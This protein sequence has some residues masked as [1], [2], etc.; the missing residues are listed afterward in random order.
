M[1]DSTQLDVVL[2]LKDQMSGKLAGIKGE[3]SSFGTNL[4]NVG[5]MVAAGLATASVAVGAFGVSS[6]KAFADAEASQNRFETA[7]RNIAHAGDDQIRM[8]RDQQNALSQTTR[9]EDD[10]IAS[11][12]GFLAT[13]QLSGEQI[14]FLTPRLL[15]MSEGLRDSTGATMG[16]EQASNML[17][18]AV[19]LGTV[20]M[21][22]KAG[23]TIP[24]TTKA[25]QDL[26]KKNFEL[27][28]IQERVKMIGDFVDGNFKGQAES[29]G[30]TLAGAIDILKNNFQ[31]LQEGIGGTLSYALV[32][33]IKTVSEFVNKPETLEWFKGMIDKMQAMGSALV[34]YLTPAFNA[35][36]DFFSDLENR[37]AAITA[38]LA[39]LTIAFVAWGVS[40]VTSMA[41]ITLA[42]VALGIVIFFLAKLWNENFGGI[43]EKTQS[44]FSGIVA[45]YQQYL[46][47]FFTEIRKKTDEVVKWWIDNW[48]TISWIFSGVWDVIRGVFTVAWALFSGAFKIAIDL[49]TGN[50]KKAWED[51]KS[52]F[53][54]IF[55]G[56]TL[57]FTGIAKTLM[58][59]LT[60]LINGFINKIN[61]VLSKINKI[62]GKD[63]K[64]ANVELGDIPAM[65][66]GTNYVPQDMFAYIHK[67]EAVVPAQYN[68]A[69]GGVGMGGGITIQI[70]GDNHF[71]NEED[72]DTLVNKIKNALSKDT[73]RAAYV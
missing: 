9:F 49:F 72:M 5:G 12:Q 30:K 37:K 69:N 65:A 32:P 42:I 4:A 70:S 31:N 11:G 53:G 66:T 63:Y 64:I 8:L 25:M 16:L 21:L 24:G 14:K 13:F 40:V 36:K 46:V 47:P 50:W 71:N 10:A 17:G 1:A 2:S 52:A 28:N 54:T 44:V 57:I 33:F 43:Q 27:A 48:N 51:A 45:F 38:V 19:Q 67:G 20:G 41:P 3:L 60:G 68:P 29:A 18:K 23:V 34:T 35:V 6:I 56:I 39:V 26:F 55:G 59:T 62:T 7:M 22:A 58:G 15:D 61:S 73:E